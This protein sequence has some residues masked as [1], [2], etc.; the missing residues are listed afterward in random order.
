MTEDLRTS[1]LETISLTASTPIFLI[2]L[3][4]CF[5]PE[6][7]HVRAAAVMMLPD[8]KVLGSEVLNTALQV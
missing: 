1:T 3:T 7:A 5:V 6:R 4:E 2:A 8:N